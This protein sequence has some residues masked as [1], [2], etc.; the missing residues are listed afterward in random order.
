MSAT[1]QASDKARASCLLAVHLILQRPDDGRVLLG[2]RKGSVWGAGR[3]HV[4]T[5]HVESGEDAMQALVREAREELGVRIDPGDLEHAVTVHHREAGG[6]P[7]MQLFFTAS[8]WSGGPVNAEPGKCE[9]LG[10]FKVD[11]LPSATV[12]YTRTALSSWRAGRSFAVCWRDSKRVDRGLGSRLIAGLQ[13][14]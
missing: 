13:A 6:E 4:P 14:I 2:L 1:R 11:E 8:R 7:Q 9:Q 5:G 3:W 10:W 12:G